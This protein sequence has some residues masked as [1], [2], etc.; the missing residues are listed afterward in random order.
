MKQARK[1]Q[2]HEVKNIDTDEYRITEWREAL[3]LVACS[4]DVDAIKEL[5]DVEREIRFKDMINQMDE[6]E[7]PIG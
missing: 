2:P 1:Q 6:D 5:R 4:G 7:L 3:D